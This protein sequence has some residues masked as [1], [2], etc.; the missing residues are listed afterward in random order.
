VDWDASRGCAPPPYAG[1]RR[2]AGGPTGEANLISWGMYCWSVITCLRYSSMA[3]TGE[4]VPRSG[5]DSWYHLQ[6]AAGNGGAVCAHTL[7]AAGG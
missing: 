6:R 5:P 1:K 7:Q 3:T 2:L 4:P